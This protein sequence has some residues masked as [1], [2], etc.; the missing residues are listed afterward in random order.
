MLDLATLGLVTLFAWTPL[1]A[2]CTKEASPRNPKDLHGAESQNLAIGFEHAY[3]D[4]YIKSTKE[5][6]FRN[7]IKYL[8]AS[9][10]KYFEKGRG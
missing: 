3:R 7:L 6:A 9:A 10:A 2:R 5:Q 1:T 8:A 4:P